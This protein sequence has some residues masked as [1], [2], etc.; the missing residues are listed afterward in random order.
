MKPLCA[1]RVEQQPCDSI[2]VRDS[3][4]A[5]RGNGRLADGIRVRLHS[6]IPILDMLHS[7]DIRYAFRLLARSP[8]FALLTSRSSS[9]AGWGSARSRSRSCTPAMIRPLPLGDGRP[10][11]P[12]HA[13][14]RGSTHAARPGRCRRSCAPRMKTVR[15][16]GGYTQREVIL[17]REG[18]RRVLDGDGHG[19][20][21]VLRRSTLG[22]SSDA[23]LLPSD[24]EPGAEPVIV[25]VAP[26]VAGRVRRGSVRRRHARRG[27]NGVS[28]RVV[29]VMPDGFGFPVTQ[30]AWLP[31]PTRS[32]RSIVAG[33][34]LRVACS[35]GSRRARPTRKRRSRRRRCSG[36]PSRPAT[37]RVAP[38]HALR[39]WRS[40]HSPP[41]RSASERTLVFTLLN[42]LAAL[43]LLLALVNVTTLLTARANE[44]IRETA[45]RLAL[46]APTGRLVMQGMWEDDH[47]LRRSAD[48]SERRARRWGLDAITRWTRANMAGQH[49][50]LVGVAAGS[51]SRC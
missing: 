15:D 49:G 31:L 41:R 28:T 16:V 5:W 35:R 3:V 27:I 37:R 6:H 2:R 9:P 20:G 40:S 34:E 30:E 51:T 42:L 50:V 43:I 12:P 36:A 23:R 21:A 46:G 17:G 48:C 22:R 24:A 18:D 7:Q 4:R 47:P 32:D 25:L 39:E 33:Q 29:G 10:H 13:G 44:R 45:V 11:R 8:G 19:P 38:W 1:A 26:H 14:G